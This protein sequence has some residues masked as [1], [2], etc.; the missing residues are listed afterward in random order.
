M[1]TI[2]YLGVPVGVDDAAHTCELGRRN[3][4]FH[5]HAPNTASNKGG[6]RT[7]ISPFSTPTTN[8]MSV[9]KP[10]TN[11]GNGIRRKKQETRDDVKK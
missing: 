4:S 8:R 5:K 11:K 10:T 1:W 2:R 9:I 3:S 6:I 7:P